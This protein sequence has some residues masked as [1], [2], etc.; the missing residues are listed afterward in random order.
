MICCSAISLAPRRRRS[1]AANRM[2]LMEIRHPRDGLD[3]ILDAREAQNP[4]RA[5]RVLL[6][7]RTISQLFT[8]SPFRGRAYI[9]E[10]NTP[11]KT[12]ILGRTLRT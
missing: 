12:Q 8:A 9:I 3:H 2:I 11:G 6:K 4:A 10:S 1:I 7:V 5:C